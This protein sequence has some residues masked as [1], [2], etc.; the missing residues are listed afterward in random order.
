MW[1]AQHGLTVA[2]AAPGTFTHAPLSLLPT[3]FSRSAFERAGTLAA[4]FGDLVAAV[5]ADADFLRTTLAG[6]CASD[7]FTA[8]LMALFEATHKQRVRCIAR[9]AVLLPS[10]HAA[11]SRQGDVELGLLRSDYMVDEPTGALLQ[12]EVNTIAASFAC[13]SALTGAPEAA[14]LPRTPCRFTLAPCVQVGCTGTKC[15]ALGW[16]ARTRPRRCRRTARWRAWRR[17]WRPAGRR[18]VSCCVFDAI[19]GHTPPLSDRG[20]ARRGTRT[21]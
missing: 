19:V 15:S 21:A 16:S 20:F 8:R 5:A 4:P 12:V 13:L 17:G 3:P 11:A 14:V 18:C 2:A 7:D 9:A 10:S 6:A 1:S